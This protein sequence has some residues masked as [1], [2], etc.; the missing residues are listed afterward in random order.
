MEVDL[1]NSV[2]KSVIDYMLFGT[3][4]EVVE[5]VVETQES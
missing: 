2:S 5:M 4:I 3:E 1:E